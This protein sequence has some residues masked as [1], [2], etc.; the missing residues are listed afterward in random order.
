MCVG[1]IFAVSSAAGYEMS[2]AASKG[3]ITSAREDDIIVSF[4]AVFDGT[5]RSSMG[6]TFWTCG[7]WFNALI[8]GSEVYPAHKRASTCLLL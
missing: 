2:G 4:S 1:F 5:L 7:E 6:E 3:W 8:A